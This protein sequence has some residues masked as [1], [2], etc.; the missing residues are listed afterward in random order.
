MAVPREFLSWV[1]RTISELNRNSAKWLEGRLPQPVEDEW[2]AG[3][4]TDMQVGW[5][6]CDPRRSGH[7]SA[8]Y[9]L[10]ETA[11]VEPE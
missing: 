7:L 4:P 3:R 11:W 8:K 9:V 6:A 5:K 1:I 10:D 2:A